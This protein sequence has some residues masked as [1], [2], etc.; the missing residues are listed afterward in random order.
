MGEVRLRPATVDDVPLLHA[1]DD[2]PDVAASGG[3]DDAFDWEYEVPRDV[4][5]RE[6]LIAEDDGRPV[7][8]LQLI[9][10]RQEETHYWGDIDHGI[11]AID[12]WIGAAAD[13]GRGVG[14]EMMR[15]A[16][17]RCFA[18]PEVH[19]VVI[20]PLVRNERAIRFYERIGFEHTGVRWF[21][22][23]ECA[24]MRITRPVR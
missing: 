12:I 11:W 20:D 4:D 13:R 18:R 14:A 17:D 5:W 10:A 16:L 9:D 7:G 19:T 24:V 22:D 21:D 23:D 1:W 8:F 15:L 6:L 2:D 3:D